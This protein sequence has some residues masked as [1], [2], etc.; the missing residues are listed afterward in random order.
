MKKKETDRTDKE[1]RGDIKQKNIIK[2]I[3][4]MEQKWEKKKIIIK[5]RKRTD[6]KKRGAG[7]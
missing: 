7:K 1:R 5:K 4:E 3:K 2:K 6:R